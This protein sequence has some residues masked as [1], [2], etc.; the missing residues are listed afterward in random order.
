MN[1]PVVQAAFLQSELDAFR[2]FLSPLAK[3]NETEYPHWVHVTDYFGNEFENDGFLC[4]EH[5]QA[6]TAKYGGD[7]VADRYSPECDVLETCNECGKQLAPVVMS[8]YCVNSELEH[9]ETL[10][11]IP[12]APHTHW[13]LRELID[14]VQSEDYEHLWA[15]VLALREKCG[16]TA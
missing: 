14:A 8:D 10:K 15:R 13:E 1:G 11:R 7:I 2:D 4:E 5:A 16:V 3:Q 6:F 12:A 9:W